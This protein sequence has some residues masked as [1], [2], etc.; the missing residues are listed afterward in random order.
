MG[1]FPL[2]PPVRIAVHPALAQAPSAAPPPPGVPARPGATLEAALAP[3]SAD[4]ARDVQDWGPKEKLL[5]LMGYQWTAAISAP[6][7]KRADGSPYIGILP[8]FADAAYEALKAGEPYF[9]KAPADMAKAA[10]EAASVVWDGRMKVQERALD[11]VKRYRLLRDRIVLD[12]AQ[13]GAS[14]EYEIVGDD[15]SN[16]GVVYSRKVGEDRSPDVSAVFS[17]R[18]PEELFSYGRTLEGKYESA[19]V[20]FQK[21][22]MS[23]TGRKAGAGPAGLL[24]LLIGA[25]VGVLAFFYLWHQ[26]E[27]E[28]RLGRWS[29]DMIARDGTLSPAE[30]ALRTGKIQAAGEMW[31]A[32]FPSKTPWAAILAAAAVAGLAFFVLPALMPGGARAT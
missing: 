7:M 9:A 31:D 3:L 15:P 8:Q 22:D 1:F 28:K 18:S 17:T 14:I 13:A 32:M 26:V 23:G 2:A 19:G 27:G 20:V 16:P 21:L 30:K 12:L 11:A 5:F 6:S 25:V 29:V 24:V 10:D 4:E